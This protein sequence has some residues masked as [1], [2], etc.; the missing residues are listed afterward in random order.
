MRR[1]VC[2]NFWAC[3][4]CGAWVCGLC[5]RNHHHAAA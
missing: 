4:L 3:G 2:Q 1:H 5:L